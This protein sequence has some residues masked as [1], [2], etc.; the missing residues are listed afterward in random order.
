[1]DPDLDASD[2]DFFGSY[3]YFVAYSC[4]HSVVG[5]VPPPFF[6][7]ICGGRFGNADDLQHV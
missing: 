2:I 1:M 4:G 3:P 5:N 7:L 6:G